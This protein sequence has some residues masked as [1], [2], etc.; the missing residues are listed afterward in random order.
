MISTSYLNKFKYA[1]LVYLLTHSFWN[2]SMGFAYS[3]TSAWLLPLKEDI[4]QQKWGANDN[5]PKLMLFQFSFTLGFF[6]GL[7][8]LTHVEA[9]P[10]LLYYDWN[11]GEK[12]N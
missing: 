2:H 1:E 3:R 6:L 4:S 12:E 5:K 9:T 7:E 10:F 11:R 8:E